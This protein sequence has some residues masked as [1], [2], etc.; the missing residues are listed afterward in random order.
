MALQ[1]GGFGPT[2]RLCVILL[3]ALAGEIQDAEIV[4][5]QIETLFGRDR[6]LAKGGFEVPRKRGVHAVF[7]VARGRKRQQ[8]EADG[9]NNRFCW[10]PEIHLPANVTTV[11]TM[12]WRGGF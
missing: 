1:G 7:V 9:D 5:R 12:T 8:G 6:E 10:D 2:K 4:L 11:P 3:D